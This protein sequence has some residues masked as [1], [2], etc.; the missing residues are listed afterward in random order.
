MLRRVGDA[1][2][3]DF[4][5]VTV[6]NLR[7]KYDVKRLIEGLEEVWRVYSKKQINSSNSSSADLPQDRSVK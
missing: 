2:P 1:L 5:E 7:E 3:L 4:R 6:E